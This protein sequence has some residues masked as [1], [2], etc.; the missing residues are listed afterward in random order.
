MTRSTGNRRSTERGDWPRRRL[1]ASLLAASLLLAACSGAGQTGSTA[2]NPPTPTPASSPTGT[3][4]GTGTDTE[5][6]AFPVTIEHKHGET[7]IESEPE[8]VV[9]VGFNEQDTLLALGVTPVAVR[10][11]FGDKPHAT[12]E[13][14]QDELGDAEPT[15]L[16]VG[17]L[18]MERIAAEE[19]DLIVGTFSGLTEEQY[20]RLSQIAPVVAQPEGYVDFG[21]PWQEQT[22]ILGRAVGRQERADE[23]VSDLESRLE[24]VREDHPEFEGA[25]G[26]VGF[27]GGGDANY[28]LYGPEDLR[29]RFMSALGFEIPDEVAEFVG[30]EFS[31]SVSRERLNLADTDVMVWVVN[32][33]EGREQLAD[34]ELYQSL[35]VAQEGRDVF[36]EP[37][38]QLAGAMSFSSVLSLPYLLDNFV[39]ML[40]TAID[41]DP[42]T[43]VS[44]PAPEPTPSPGS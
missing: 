30:D 18:D 15:V 11:W 33:P 29:S 8:R 28:H 35:D 37:N 24:S 13:W 42:G 16:P 41:G 7:T 14:A 34:E 40:E 9:S 44:A 5:A 17:E 26:M 4:T 2:Q 27:L 38:G 36:L 22:R 32:D 43:E 19:P 6:A 20:D 31:A 23:L 12:W 39:P 3:G 25:S 21:V 1:V 10:E